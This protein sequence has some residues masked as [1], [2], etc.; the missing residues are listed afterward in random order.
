MSFTSDCPNQTYTDKTAVGID[1]REGIVKAV[2]FQGKWNGMI[3][4]LSHNTSDTWIPVL[5]NGNID[6]VLKNEIA[7]CAYPVGSI[8][9]S[10][11]P[12]SPASLFGGS[13]ESIASERVLMG[14]SKSN[15]AGK[16]VNAGLPNI[17]GDISDL[18][19]GHSF[20][21]TNGVFSASSPNYN[22]KYSSGS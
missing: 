1:C 7:G 21:N 13:W 22:T 16:T 10:T 12:T 20:G 5:S 11:D 17:T 14:V 19:V 6:Y 18:F 2:D 3:Q 15:G 4:R 9:Q 8:Y